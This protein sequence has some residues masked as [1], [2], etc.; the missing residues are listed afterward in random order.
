M[1]WLRS[2]SFSAGGRQRRKEGRKKKNV[3][4]TSTKKLSEKRQRRRRGGKKLAS[5]CFLQV[6]ESQIFEYFSLLLVGR[7]GKEKKAREPKIHT[8][9]NNLPP[10]L[11]LFLAFVQ[12]NA[13]HFCC[14]EFIH[15]DVN[16]LCTCVRL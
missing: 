8:S 3:G 9:S 16:I 14:K 5:F 2:S 13:F 10:L 15:F 11:T 1:P 6:D 12:V 4:E 7:T